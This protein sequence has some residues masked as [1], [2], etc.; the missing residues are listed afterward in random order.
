MTAGVIRGEP[1]GPIRHTRRWLAGIHP[2]P[3]QDGFPITNVGNDEG[4]G[5]R[6]ALNRV[7]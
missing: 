4:G 7:T 1:Y 3:T 6:Q 2:S 5:R